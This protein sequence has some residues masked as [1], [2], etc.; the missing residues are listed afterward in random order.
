MSSRL[1]I[2]IDLVNKLFN[3]NKQTNSLT[4]GSCVAYGNV[5]V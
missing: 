2:V 5:T 3:K 4:T 1:Q